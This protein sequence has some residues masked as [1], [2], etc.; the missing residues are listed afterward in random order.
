MNTK[1]IGRI[2]LLNLLIIASV[3]QIYADDYY[4]GTQGLSGQELVDTLHSII[5]DHTYYSYQQA[6]EYVF[7]MNEEDDSLTCVYS[8]ERT[9]M[10]NPIHFQYFN[11]EHTWPQSL[12]EED[13]L[14]QKKSDMHHLYPTNP[15]VNNL[16]ANLPFGDIHTV[17]WVSIYDTTCKYGLNMDGEECF[18]PR[19][20]HKGDAARALF[21]F[22]IRYDMELPDITGWHQEILKE[23]HTT[24]P[25]DSSEITRNEEVYILQENRNPFIDH[26]EFV[27]LIDF[28]DFSNPIGVDDFDY[29]KTSLHIVSYP[30]PFNSSTNISFFITDYTELNG[31]T[32]IKIYNIKG[33]LI[34]T[35]TKQIGKTGECKIIWNGKDDYRKDIQSG[36]YLYQLKIGKN[37][38]SGKITLIR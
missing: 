26:P 22:A 6:G 8:G 17:F 14:A 34:N 9:P 5:D 19:D 35:L 15:D 1:Y 28:E 21:Y 3:F 18:E 10:P 37:V 7:I 36:I 25:P 30:N 33:E 38:H 2:I 27:D 13:E 11:R 20:C 16:R 29:I 31:L 4:A 12:F 24:D 32:E 23:W